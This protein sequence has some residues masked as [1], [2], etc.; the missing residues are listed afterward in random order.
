MLMVSACAVSVS[1]YQFAD[2]DAIVAADVNDAVNALA[3]LGVIKGREDGKF[4]PNDT[5]TREEACVIF[6]KLRA[7]S[8]GQKYEWL[9][10][11]TV[12]PDVT[13]KWSFAYINYAFRNGFMTG[14]GTNFNPKGVLTIEQALCA[15]VKA[16][17]GNGTAED[18]SGIARYAKRVEAVGEHAYWAGHYT[19]IAVELGL[20][21]NVPFNYTAPCTR[22]TMAQIAYNLSKVDISIGKGFGLS[23][24]NGTLTE[25]AADTATIGG[26]KVVRSVLEAALA[27]NGFDGTLT[28]YIGAEFT[29]KYDAEDGTV[30]SA[31]LKSSM[32]VFDFTD[33]ILSINQKD[34][35]NLNTLTL[36][37]TTYCAKNV[38]TNEGSGL[39][40]GAGKYPVIDVTYTASD[41]TGDVNAEIASDDGS[42]LKNL[43]EYYKAF[44]YDDDFDGKYDRLLVKEYTI[45]TIKANTKD[46]K[47]GVAFD[48]VTFFKGVTFTNYEKHDNKAK[49]E[50]V[51]NPTIDAYTP[52]LINLSYN[53]G[54]N[55]YVVDT[56]EV[57]A[58]KTGL[59]SGIVTGKSI[60]I[61][62][63]TIAFTGEFVA[64]ASTTLNQNVTIF[65]IAGKY[66]QVASTDTS[67]IKTLLVE[68]VKIN[69]D[70]NAVVTGYNV[71]TR[72]AKEEVTVVGL[73][74]SKLVSYGA[75]RGE[76][77]N[78]DGSK[79]AD[80]IYLA[81]KKDAEE[82]KRSYIEDGK[83]Y[84]FTITDKGAYL[85]AT[86]IADINDLFEAN[87]A[88]Y[89][90]L[91]VGAYVK[92]GATP[93]AKYNVDAP[94]VVKII[95]DAEAGKKD[96]YNAVKY[97]V[98]ESLS[99]LEEVNAAFFKDYKT[100]AGA[101]DKVKV[102]VIS[103]ASI[104][105]KTI[106]T[107]PFAEGETLVQVIAEAHEVGF[108]AD[109]Y[110]A[111]DLINGKVVNVTGVD[112][113][114]GNYYVANA[115]LELG[116]NVD[117]KWVFDTKETD[118]SKI[119]VAYGDSILPTV[120]AYT[121]QLVKGV[122]EADS[123]YKP[124][125]VQDEGKP[126]EFSTVNQIKIFAG[127]GA[128]NVITLKDEAPV[129]VKVDDFVARDLAVKYSADPAYTYEA[130]D[131]VH[132]VYFEAV[133]TFVVGDSMIIVID[134]NDVAPEVE[135]E[136]TPA[137]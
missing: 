39:I 132:S 68:S 9:E 3:D 111:V 58:K 88:S 108:D 127:D 44:A 18:P 57:A 59:V 102:V 22:G 13:A 28:D 85:T 77:E 33:V 119:T 73:A 113:E 130:D 137:E 70:G 104:D 81:T 26:L 99:A 37:G 89:V 25:V 6:A 124:D 131:G 63:E 123:K 34:N 35:K 136:E 75:F 120:T 51:G 42:I 82:A 36:A 105:G 61:G 16:Y 128:E 95:E 32:L 83:Y 49:M 40:G 45:A 69:E 116:A 14:D 43:P 97:S 84:S 53:T 10:E 27:D 71:D 21:E 47:D 12:F 129:M 17:K 54:T 106:I 107:T 8:E 30:Y 15:A 78:A 122:Q 91:S 23:D 62:G 38:G 121:T 29:V 103:A 96:V 109:T 60:K 11:T 2:Q 67:V 20:T 134:I 55:T 93:A 4:Y 90:N 110:K 1:A 87:D 56:L 86:A 48:T 80:K 31:A 52:N 50:Y 94:A 72:F 115:N 79:T 66:V 118:I 117:G 76:I 101:T 125:T 112:A 24:L 46:A 74:G 19:D 100:V 92:Y 5:L 126:K 98:S 7:G 135:E 114:V 64:P 41:L 133:D 65:T